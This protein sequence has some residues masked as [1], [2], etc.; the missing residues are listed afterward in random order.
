MSPLFRK[1][2]EK[3]AA[4]AAA[5]AEIDRLRALSTIDLAVDL[6][7]GLGPDGP[8]NGNIIPAQELAIKYLLRDHPG[9]GKLQRLDLVGPTTRA[10]NKLEEEGLVRS[11]NYQRTPMWRITP[12]GKTALEDGTVRERLGW[13]A[14][15]A[16][17]TRD[18]PAALGP[19]RANMRAF[20]RLLG[21]NSPGGSLVVEPGFV[22]AIVPAC[23]GQS[24]VNAV[25]YED[26]QTL[27]ARHAE[28]VEAY[29]QAG[30][31]VWRVW[32]PEDDRATAAYLEE[33]GHRMAGS[34]RA[35]ALD[36]AAL[37]GEPSAVRGERGKDAAV[38]AAL[39]EE[40]L[41]LSAGELGAVT[42]ALAARS[43][44]YV[45]REDGDP[46]ACAVALDE[47]GD[48]GIYCVATRPA[49]RRHGLATGLVRQALLEA[50]SR[51]CTS[52]SL[53]SSAV[54]FSVYQQIGYRDCGAL[55]IWEYRNA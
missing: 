7:P 41:G 38:L 8:R 1:S 27:R 46:A 33:A 43:E 34:A 20:Y 21:A 49:S 15:G 45:A 30:V 51:G 23:P 3:E 31:S 4:Q 39:N 10:L 32:V 25:V 44:F 16:A 24:V 37:G 55:E 9:A 6:L 42:P 17:A 19:M 13:V 40:A 54:G 14:A 28:L 26:P 52:S 36:L 18:M 22:A 29:A 47:G 50:R 12:D 53:Q 35:M 2:P 48:C 11:Y 5:K